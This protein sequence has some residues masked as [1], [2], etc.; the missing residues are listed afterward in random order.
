VC[1]AKNVYDDYEEKILAISLL[2]EPIDFRARNFSC[3]ARSPKEESILDGV[4]D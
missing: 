3:S 4:H 2:N 1:I